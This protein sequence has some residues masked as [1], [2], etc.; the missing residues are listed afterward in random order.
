M[1]D[2]ANAAAHGMVSLLVEAEKWIVRRHRA[3]GDRP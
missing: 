3:R 2:S 1:N